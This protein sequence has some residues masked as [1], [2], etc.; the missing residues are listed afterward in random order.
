MVFCLFALSFTGATTRLADTQGVLLFL[1]NCIF[2]YMV[3]VCSEREGNA[4]IASMSEA[5]FLINCSFPHYEAEWKC[6]LS[7]LS[8]AGPSCPGSGITPNPSLLFRWGRG[9]RAKENNT[10]K[11]FRKSVNWVIYAKYPNNK[12]NPSWNEH[13]RLIMESYS[14]KKW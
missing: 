3:N 14:W 12:V 10:R 5:C 4:S 11:S 13:I 6:L 1:N 7:P 2:I 9:K 8:A